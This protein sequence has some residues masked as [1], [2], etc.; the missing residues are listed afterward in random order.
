MTKIK[1]CGLKDSKHIEQI[2]YQGVDAI[3]TVVNVPRSARSISIQHALSIRR[4]I[5]PFI[6]HVCVTVPETIVDALSLEEKLRPDVLQV[7]ALEKESFF[8]ELRRIIKTK[9]VLALPIDESGNSRLIDK[10]PIFAS[11]VLTKY[12]DALLIDSYSAKTIGGSGVVHDWSIAKKVRES[13]NVP[14][15]LSG[16]LTPENVRNAIETVQP[17]A[18]DVSS[19]VESAPGVKDIDLIKEFIK[20]SRE[21]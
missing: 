16:G 9:L 15:I 18:V 14:L 3:G 12:C 21:V 2:V 6:S 7:H 19:G 10:D 8:K 17:F 4:S 11:Q 1:I 5:P 13:I 20:N